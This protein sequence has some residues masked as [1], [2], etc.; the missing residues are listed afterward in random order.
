[1][2]DT[3]NHYNRLMPDDGYS[4]HIKIDQKYIVPAP[5]NM[6]NRPIRPFCADTIDSITYRRLL[7]EIAMLGVGENVDVIRDSVANV[8]NA[9]D[10]NGILRM[11]FDLPH[12]KR[13]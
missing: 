12:N 6:G 7:T 1:M 13:Y 4:I 2:A 9:I 3:L 10:A 5:L 8:E 11:K